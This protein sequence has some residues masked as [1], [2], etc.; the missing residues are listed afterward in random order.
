MLADT[1]ESPGNAL[2]CAAKDIADAVRDAKLEDYYLCKGK[3][4]AENPSAGISR[5]KGRPFQKQ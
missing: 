2:R 5:Y 3:V 4:T 1:F